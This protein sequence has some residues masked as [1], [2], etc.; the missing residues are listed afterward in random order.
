MHL[1]TGRGPRRANV[2]LERVER[3]EVELRAR[4]VTVNGNNGN[5]RTGGERGRDRRASPVR[6]G[7]IWYG[8]GY[9]M[10]IVWSG[11]VRVVS[12]RVVSD[13]VS[14]AIKSAPKKRK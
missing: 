12:C 7:T 14:V 10:V 11:S 6:Y 13:R 4:S 1:P 5:V 2:Q 9:G 3:E 8:C